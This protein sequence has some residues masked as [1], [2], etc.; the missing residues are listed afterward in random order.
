M[1]TQ[2]KS[3]WLNVE[4]HIQAL[5]NLCKD[6]LDLESVEAVQ[7]YIDHDEYEMAF[8][9]LFIELMKLGRLPNIG[10]WNDYL[11]LGHSLGLDK[12]SVFDAE[13]WPRFESFVLRQSG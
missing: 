8:E 7:H 1:M 5:L 11:D 4:N 13:F 12:E 10:N 9:G 3:Y 6:S 2:D